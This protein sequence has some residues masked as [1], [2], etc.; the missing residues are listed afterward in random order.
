MF[1][2]WHLTE[3]HTWLYAG[4]HVQKEVEDGQG[5]HGGELWRRNALSWDLHP[6]SQ[7]QLWA[8]IGTDGEH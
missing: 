6:G 7:Q 2:A 8:R 3:T 1:W 5:K 4:H